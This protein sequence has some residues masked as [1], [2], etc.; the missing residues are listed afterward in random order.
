MTPGL[1]ECIH[2][3][4]FPPCSGHR[5]VLSPQISAKQTTWPLISFSPESQPSSN[6]H[7]DVKFPQIE[8]Q[9]REVNNLPNYN[10]QACT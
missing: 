7:N 6:S 10:V 4:A 5:M 2:L 9:P 1:S 3:P 8:K